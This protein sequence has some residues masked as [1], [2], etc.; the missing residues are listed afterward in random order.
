MPSPS[1]HRKITISTI[2]TST[3]FLVVAI[4]CSGTIWSSIPSVSAQ[5][6]TGSA[7]TLQ[8]KIDQRNQDIK[9][10]EQEIA[11][12]QKQIDSLS[13]QASSLSS[14]IKSLQLTQKKLA[15]DIKV[16]E[17]K[18][19]E[20]NL[21]IQQLST[22][23][24]ASQQNID[25]D[26]RI[27]AN[28]LA[29]IQQSDNTTLIETILGSNSVSETLDSLTKL[30]TIQS[31]LLDRIS[32]YKDNKTTL[33]ST[34]ARTEKARA[35]L[36]SLNK[37]I[38]D[39]KAIVV[40]TTAQQ[41]SLLK[42]T[43]QSE[44]QYQK[45]LAERLKLKEAFEQEI[46]TY[47]SQLTTQV[48]KSK[49]PGT[50]SGV[51]SWPLDSISIT[52]YFGNT[53]FSTANP[54]IYNGKGHTGV[55]FRATIGTPVK[56]ALSGT[57]IGTGNTD[58]VPG[59]YSFGKWIMIKHDNGLSTLYAHLSLPIVS[60]G[61][62]VSTGQIIGYSGNTGYTTGPHLHFGVY[63]TQGVQIQPLVS[64]TNCHNAVIPIAPFQAYLNPL[65]YLP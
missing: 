11:G 4:F 53:S 38:K 44:A 50:G 18:I 62:Y 22:Q 57:I 7:A 40:S 58:L 28:T 5:T 3:V 30:G 8:S 46:L 35:D 37:Q 47:Q 56:A 6:I 25:D 33:E 39:Q 17:N 63:A 45:T 54:Q 12:Y 20:R 32:T 2:T 23:I 48:D 59:C 64:S 51:L 1:C 41:N 42:D 55:D 27:I 26:K 14:T 13:G 31:Q 43:K 15:D 60:T 9:N 65:S 29:T 36:L 61:T 24:T 21:E 16:T 19:S 52:Q 34:K 10:L 49:I